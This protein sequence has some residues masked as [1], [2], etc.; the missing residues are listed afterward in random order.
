[1]DFDFKPDLPLRDE[2]LRSVEPNVCP[3]DVAIAVAGIA[4]SDNVAARVRED[5]GFLAD[6]VRSNSIE[7]VIDRLKSLGFPSDPSFL[8]DIERNQIDLALRHK[9]GNPITLAMILAGIA[10]EIELEYVGINFPQHFLARIDQR[11]IDP[12]QMRIVTSDEM[13]AWAKRRRLSSPLF[14]RA[15]NRDIALRMLNNVRL[16]LCICDRPVDA[17]T[18]LDYKNLLAGD[19]PEILIEKSEVWLDMGDIGMGKALLE[20]AMDLIDS[21]SLKEVIRRRVQLLSDVDEELN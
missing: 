15:S 4:G 7:E 10:E 21:S 12:L 20:Q 14:L 1:M 16:A 11:L 18:V 19:R 2:L 3:V 6:S 5:I 17:L 8:D 13:R 9:S